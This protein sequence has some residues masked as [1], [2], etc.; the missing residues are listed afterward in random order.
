LNGVYLEL[1]DRT[2]S[3][4]DVLADV[5]FYD[6]EGRVVFTSYQKEIPYLLVKWLHDAVAKEGWPIESI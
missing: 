3:Q 2:G 4:I 1:S 6:E 5:F